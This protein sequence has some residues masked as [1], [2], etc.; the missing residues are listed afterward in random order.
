ML[1]SEKAESVDF[2]KD[3]FGRMVSAV[4]VDYQGLAVASVTEL[5]DQLRE[6]DVEY[7]VVKNTLTKLALKDTDYIGDLGEALTGMTAIAWSYEEPGAAAKVFK[8]FAR[9]HDSLKVKAGII[10]GN[11]IDGEA[12]LGQLATMPGRD[13]LRAMLLATLQAPAQQFLQQLQA[14]AQNLLYLLTAKKGEE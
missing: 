2:I 3:R 10:D 4:L 6:K 9:T 7:K 1:R 12:V 14:P 11:V 5:R 8:E 13:E